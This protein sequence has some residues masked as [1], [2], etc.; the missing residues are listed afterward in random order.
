MAAPDGRLVV[1]RGAPPES[2]AQGL[3]GSGMI[4]EVDSVTAL[5]DLIVGGAAAFLLV[6]VL[7]SVANARSAE[8]QKRIVTGVAFGN[9]IVLGV[10]ISPMSSIAAELV[11][12]SAV[13]TSQYIG[14]ISWLVWVGTVLEIVFGL[15]RMHGGS[16]WLGDL[17]FASAFVGGLILPFL[18]TM[19][20]GLVLA[21]F[22]AVLMELSPSDQWRGRGL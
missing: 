10:G 19:T 17:A 14:L 2:I 11:P 9:G 22:G 6:V 18:E 1:R 20:A 16:G 12:L 15:A 8:S 21:V 5:R 4:P 3:Q 7:Q 13:L